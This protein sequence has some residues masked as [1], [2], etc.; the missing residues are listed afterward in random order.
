MLDEFGRPWKDRLLTPIV[1][2]M[3]AAIGPTTITTVAMLVGVFAAILAAYRMWWGAFGLFWVNRLL[4]GLDGLVARRRNETS[5]LGGY[6]DILF[7]FVVYAAIPIGVWFGVGG[8]TRAG[9][10]VRETVAGTATAETIALVALLAVFYVN[11]ASWMYLSAII[12]KR[13]AADRGDTPQLTSVAMPT[14]LVEGTETIVFFTLILLFPQRAAILFSVM[15]IA[16]TIGIVQR[17]V[18]AFRHLRNESTQ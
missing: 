2:A 3:P 11:G 7:D 16:T 10:T 1:D 6:L 4:D 15:A 8:A 13:N 18:W 12:E 14:G 9:Q 5:D 17:V